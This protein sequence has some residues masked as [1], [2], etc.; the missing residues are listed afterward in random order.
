MDEPAISDKLIQEL[1][2]INTECFLSDDKYSSVANL[3][4][5]MNTGELHAITLRRNRKIIAYI[6]Y[7]EYK[8]H[9]ESVRRGVAASA[10]GAGVGTRISKKLTKLAREKGKDVYT[11]VSK[12]NLPS[13]NSNIK[14]GWR[15][16]MIDADWVYLHYKAGQ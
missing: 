1:A 15:I 4:Y 14:I 13:L 10:R 8:D 3:S 6:L 5:W 7:R 2:E 11:Y 16:Y 12:T 9:L